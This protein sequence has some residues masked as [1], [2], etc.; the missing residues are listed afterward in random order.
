MKDFVKQNFALVLAFALPLALITIIAVGAYLPSLFLSTDHNF[1]YASCVD[2]SEYRPQPCD[3]YLQ[4][5]YSVGEGS[6]VVNNIDPNQDLDKNGVLD[7]KESYTARLF[8]H[9]TKTNESREITIEE[10]KQL[11]LNNLLTSP[12]GV[13]ISS[14]YSRAP[15]MFPFFGGGSSY[16]HYLTKGKSK[17]RLNLIN[18]NGR[19]YYQN[20]FQFI[21]WVLPGRSVTETTIY[22]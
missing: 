10:A 9:D 4:Q 8:L 21:G 14:D 5:R 19:Y 17:T 16:G 6:L 20:N 22:E 15:E 3:K 11:T 13:S 7:V 1:V 18:D 12:D 2:G